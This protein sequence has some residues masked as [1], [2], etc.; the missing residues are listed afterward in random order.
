LPIKRSVN[1]IFKGHTIDQV[2]Q[3]PS[4]GRVAN[5]Q[6]TMATPIREKIVQKCGHTTNHVR[7][8]VTV[9]IRLNYVF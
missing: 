5:N 1:Q 9:W 6:H 2:I 4:R 3:R 7:I 8:A